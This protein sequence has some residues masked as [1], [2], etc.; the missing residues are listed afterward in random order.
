[1]NELQRAREWRT[2]LAELFSSPLAKW[3]SVREKKSKSDFDRGRFFALNEAICHLE[4]TDGE[5]YSVKVLI[6]M[7]EDV[8]ECL[9]ENH[10]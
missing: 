10:Q 3:L 9:K 8:E 2:K 7:L 5:G 4:E 1:M 6:K